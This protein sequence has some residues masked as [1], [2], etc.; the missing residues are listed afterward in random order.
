[1]SE[2]VPVAYQT[3]V[4]F[5]KLYKIPVTYKQDGKQKRMKKT[6]EMFQNEIRNFEKANK[7]QGGL[8]Y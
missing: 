1:M 8:Y 6:F 3:Y 7:I 4:K 5:A 2:G